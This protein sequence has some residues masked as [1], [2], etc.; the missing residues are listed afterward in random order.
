MDFRNGLKSS[1]AIE[2]ARILVRNSIPNL[3]E[4]RVME[5][6]L[7]IAIQFVR[8]GEII[9]EVEDRLKLN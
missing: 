5:K 7:Q 9:K 4:D 8:S 2:N 6:D 1:P 3:E